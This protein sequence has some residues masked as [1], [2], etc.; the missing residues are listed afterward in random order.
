MATCIQI[1]TNILLHSLYGYR[2]T[3]TSITKYIHTH[4]YIDTHTHTDTGEMEEDWGVGEI[5]GRSEKAE[6]G[7][8]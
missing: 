8:I 6:K 5:G 2:N 3:Y 7:E 4:V 1:R